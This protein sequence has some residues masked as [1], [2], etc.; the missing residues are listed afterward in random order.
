[1]G[2]L[3]A[4]QYM[5]KMIELGDV[6]PTGEGEGDQQQFMLT[7]QGM[8]RAKQLLV[9]AGIVVERENKHSVDELMGGLLDHLAGEGGRLVISYTPQSP[10]EESPDER[11]LVG[12]EFGREAEDSDMAGG[13]SYGVNATLRDA[14]QHVFDEVGA[15]VPEE[16]G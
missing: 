4:E 9:A 10:E 13:A 14:L 16:V 6:V 12:Y 1:M 11:W 3:T 7:Q 15:V 2:D 5:A 8:D